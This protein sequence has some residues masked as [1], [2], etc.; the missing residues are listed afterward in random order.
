ME[1]PYI[2]SAAES[3]NCEQLQILLEKDPQLINAE[4]KRRQ[5]PLHYAAQNSLK[6]TEF[7]IKN[8]ADVNARDRNGYTAI[9]EASAVEIA[10]V[11]I[12]NGADINIAGWRA[13]TPLK[14]A[15]RRQNSDLVRYLISQGADV[16]YVAEIDFRETITQ[17]TISTI[18]SRS[19]EAE[20][21]KALEILEILLEAGA[22]PNIQSVDGTTVLHEASY[23]GL[24][25]FVKLLL[26]Y[27]A[28]PC[29]RN[30]WGKS[31]FEF[32]ENFPEIIELFEPYR[33]NLQ[34]VIEIQDSPE[35]LVER[36]LNIDFVDRSE[37]KPCSEAEIADLENRNR[38]RLPES[39]KKFLRIMGNGAGWFLKSDHWEAFYSD[40]DDWLGVDF[41]KIPE[42]EYYQCTQK[43][44][45]L[46]LKVPNNFFVFATRLGDYPLGFFADGTDEDPNIYTIND[47]ESDLKLWGKSFWKFF[48]DMVE[49]YEYYCD[50]NKHSK[51]AVPWSANYTSNQNK[52]K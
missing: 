5:K 27:D 1:T 17:S 14:Y 26:K 40:F 32:A 31:S 21:N 36:L 18:V 6:C 4:D 45:D 50:R 42:A 35:R 24:T 29:V 43:E 25:E 22:D 9:F 47:D 30:I 15:I 12:E 16:N 33:H 3:G 46:S 2:H 20:K 51:T 37:F 48:Q 52:L 41:Y 38:V 28:D 23:K 34:P 19:S 39:Y 10:Q 11:L 7:L 49:H 8:G 44:I 13:T